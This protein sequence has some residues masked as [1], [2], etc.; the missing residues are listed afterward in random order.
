APVLLALFGREYVDQA[1]WTLRVLSVSTVAT[2]LNYWGAL[3]LRLSRH[4]TWMVA[5]QAASTVTILV[6]AWVAAPHGTV[7]VA[8]AWG[9]GHLVG[10]V[11]GLAVTST[12]APVAD[13]EPVAEPVRNGGENA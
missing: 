10:G 2:A 12:L 7:W 8:A 13:E 9:A 6:L 11:L 3:R 1:T 5:V 4:H